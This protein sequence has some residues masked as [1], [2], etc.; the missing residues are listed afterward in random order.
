MLECTR[1]GHLKVY[2]IK[3]HLWAQAL[4]HKS[5]QHLQ[6]SWIRQGM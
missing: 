1:A 5:W 2:N 6:A 4:Q 3:A